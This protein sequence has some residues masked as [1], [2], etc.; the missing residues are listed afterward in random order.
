MIRSFFIWL[1]N[2][3]GKKY[4]PSPAIPTGVLMG[5]LLHRAITLLRGLLRFRHR[6]FVESNVKVRGK[7]RLVLGR[8]VTLQEQVRIDAVSENGVSLGDRTKIGA[9]THIRCTN[10]L[11][12]LG[13]GVQ[14]GRDCGIGQFSFIG[15]AG[16]VTIGDNVIMG[17]YV[18]FHAQQ[19][20]FDQPGKPIREQ[21]ATAEGITIEPDVWV[22]AKVT[23]LDGT[24]IGSHSVVA[25]GAVVKGVFP[26]NSIIGGV[27]A[28]VIKKIGE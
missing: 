28:R 11:A 15:A 4:Q 13:K 2:K 25:A 26:P 27:P 7:G 17:Q 5:E 19:H 12:L 1:L 8:Y 21:G 22:G 9:Y 3:V 10:H 14:I 20:V 16:G 23:F 18:S 24:H 6:V